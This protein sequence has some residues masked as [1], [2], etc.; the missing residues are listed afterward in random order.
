MSELKTRKVKVTPDL[1]KRW[2]KTNID[3]RKLS[4]E[5]VRKLARD[6]TNDVFPNVGETLKFDEDGHLIDGQHRLHAVVLSEKTVEFIVVEGIERDHRYKMDRVRVRKASDELTMRH[7]IPSAPVA[8][9]ATRLILMWQIEV[10]KSETFKPTDSEI[11]DFIV[12]HT[13]LINQAVR[14]SMTLRTEIGA[15]P[16][17]TAALYFLTHEIDAAEALQFWDLVKTGESL[18]K[19]DPELTL[20]NAIMRLKQKG[21][22]KNPKTFMAMVA[23]AWNARREGRK[24]QVLAPKLPPDLTDDHFR[25]A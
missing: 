24:I 21:G 23:K 18:H 12:T 6:M 16:S 4:D 8:V 10:I 3:N 15:L 13:E 25:L 17:S 20:R 22:E 5:W 1:A 14:F 11:I 19:G 2:L 7:H 9:G